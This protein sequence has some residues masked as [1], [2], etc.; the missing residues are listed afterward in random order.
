MGII[1]EFRCPSCHK[2]WRLS[3][4]HGMVHGMLTR[5][6][7]I[8]PSDIQKKISEDIGSE[9]AP[10]FRFNY[11]IGACHQCKNM[12]AVPVFELIEQGQVYTAPCPKC[13][14]EVTIE[15]ESSSV[16]CPLCQDETLSVQDMG[17][18]D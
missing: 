2:T 5:V 18:W 10:L 13:G 8:F 12:V 4:G 17:H 16:L 15:Q 9:E 3:I 11:K 14:G 7:K 6:L 1:R